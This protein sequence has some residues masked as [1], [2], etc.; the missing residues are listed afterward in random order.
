MFYEAGH[1]SGEFNT[2]LEV[3]V[4]VLVFPARERQDGGRGR[5]EGKLSCFGIL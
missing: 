2:E 4:W 5:K 1:F 3:D